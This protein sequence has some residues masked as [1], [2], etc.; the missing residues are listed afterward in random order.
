MRVW[1]DANW[2]DLTMRPLHWL[3]A[4]GWLVHPP[5]AP[6]QT[7]QGYHLRQSWAEVGRAIPCR[8]DS[9]PDTW[10]IKVKDCSPSGGDVRLTF[11]RDTLYLI[12]YVPDADSTRPVTPDDTLPADA[13]WNR[14]W[15]AWSIRRFG[16][17]DSVTT[18]T[19]NAVGPHVQQVT[20][21]WHKGSTF[22]QIEIMSVPGRSS[23]YVHAELC[24]ELPGLE[25]K[26]SWF[27]LQLHAK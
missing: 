18:S 1:W 16:A 3:C 25:C 8:T 24:Q 23:G 6:A 13:L 19:G 21:F 22:V 20:A 26:S 7:L 9:L 2:R 10:R 5:D 27:G 12:S 14:R 11:I 17:P 4:I 15:K